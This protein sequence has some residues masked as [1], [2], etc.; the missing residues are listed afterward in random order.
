MNDVDCSLRVVFSGGM[1]WDGNLKEGAVNVGPFL[2]PGM[3]WQS[4]NGESHLVSYRG[5]RDDINALIREKSLQGWRAIRGALDEW[6]ISDLTEADAERGDGSRAR[7]LLGDDAWRD[8]ERVEEESEE[9]GLAPP[10]G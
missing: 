5:W 3:L 9:N 1:S 10:Q 7:I 2:R 8:C 4:A 6:A